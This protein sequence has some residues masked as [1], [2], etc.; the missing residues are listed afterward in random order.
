MTTQTPQLANTI[1]LLMRPRL[2]IHSP[3]RSPQQPHN[4]LLHPRLKPRH[5][6]P[7]QNQRHIHIPDFISIIRHDFVGML[8]EFGGVASLPSGIGVLEDLTDVGEGEGAEN[9]VDE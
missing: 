2:N 8:H 5:F 3:L 6:R 4:I 1:H 7:L 9:G